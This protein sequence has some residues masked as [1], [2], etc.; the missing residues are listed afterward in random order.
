LIP[1]FFAGHQTNA[2]GTLVID[3]SRTKFLF[4]SNDSQVSLALNNSLAATAAKIQLDLLTPDDTLLATAELTTTVSKGEHSVFMHLPFKVASLPTTRTDL[5]WLRLRCRIQ[6]ADPS[7]SAVTVM[8]LAQIAPELFEVQAFASPMLHDRMPY[9]T[10]VRAFNPHTNA[11]AQSVRIDGKLDFTTKTDVQGKRQTSAIT[12]REGFALLTFDLPANQSL[13]DLELT[14]TGT[15]GELRVQATRDVLYYDEPRLL[16]STDKPLYQPGQTLHIR[17]LAFG[18]SMHALANKE[19][20]LK[21]NDPEGSL[22]FRSTM[23]TSRFGVAFADWPIPEHSRLGDYLIE[24][25]LDD[26]T[27]SSRRIK[28]SRYELPNFSIK[29]TPD[30]PYYVAGQSAQVEVRA[31]YLFGQP[32]KQGHVRVVRE[33]EREWNYAEQKYDIDEG[34]SY[35]GDTDA[36]GSFRTPIDLSGEHEDFSDNSYSKFRDLRFAA[37]FTDPTTNRTEQRRFSLRITKEPIHVY[38]IRSASGRES[39]RSPLSFYLTTY[40]ADG[41]P[42]SCNVQLRRKFNNDERDQ[43]APLLRTVQTNKLGVAKVGRLL[44]PRDV[45]EGEDF[46]LAMRARDQQGRTGTATEDFDLYDEP[47]ITV[48]TNKNL[49]TPGEPIEVTI[50]SSEKEVSA[51]LEILH[52]WISL[53]SRVIKLHG[54][55]T[56]FTLP[57][58]DNYKDALIIAAYFMREDDPI[59][60]TQTVLFPRDQNLRLD[61]RSDQQAYR[62]GDSAH[63][64]FRVRN[65]DNQPSESSLGVVV[66]DQAVAERMRDLEQFDSSSPSFYSEFT[67]LLGVGESVAGL[68]RA[69]LDH[70]DLSRPVAP[71]LALAAELFLNSSYRYFVESCGSDHYV[72]SSENVF[73]E[74]I[75]KQLKQAEDVIWQHY[76]RTDQYPTDT[77]STRKI[78]AAANINLDQLLDPWGTPYRLNFFVA[79]KS[80][81]LELTTAGVDRRFGTN[82]DFAVD[83]LDW[84]YFKPIR[85]AID[86]ALMSYHE[87]TGGFIRDQETL[88]HEL[89]SQGL[90]LMTL[91]DRWSQPYNFSFNV[92]QRGLVLTISSNGPDRK[93]GGTGHLKDDFEIWDSTVDYFGDLRT[94]VNAALQEWSLSHKSFPENQA[95]L[96]AALRAG[97][98]EPDS[99]RDDW[100]NPYQLEL[101]V[102]QIYGDKP[103]VED[104]GH[105]GETPHQH[106]DLVPVTNLIGLVNLKS[107]GPD[108]KPDTTDDLEIGT[109]AGVIKSQSSPQS[110]TPKAQSVEPLLS[111]TGGIQGIVKDVNYAVVPNV[112]VTA[113]GP[114]TAAI[115][116]TT[117][118]TGSYWLRDLPAGIYEVYAEASGFKTL[119][120]TEVVVVAGQ[121]VDLDLTMNP[122]ALAETVNVTAAADSMQ[123]NASSA[124]ISELRLNGRNFQATYLRSK[125]AGKTRQATST[126]RLRDYFPETLV[127]QPSLETD[128]RGWA[129]L[130]FKLADNITT[131][132]MSVI[133]STEDGQIGVVDK[134]IKAFQPFFIELDPPKVLTEGDEI[135][136]PVVVRNYLAKPQNVSLEIKPENWFALLSAGNRTTHVAASDAARETFALRVTSAVENGKQRVTARAGDADDAIEKPVTVHPDGEERSVSTGNVSD[137]NA[138]LQFEIPTNAIPGSARGRLKIYP[139]LASHVAESVEAIMQRPYGCGEQTISSTYP[140]LLLVRYFKQI[141]QTSRLSAQAERYLQE[142][143]NRL[144]NY[145]ADSGGFTYWGRGDADIALTAYALRFLNDAS[146]LIA[147][148]DDVIEG[149][150]RWLVHVQR[151]DGSWVNSI[152]ANRMEDIRG[153]PLLSAYVLRILAKV[154]PLAKTSLPPEIKSDANFEKALAFLE[155][156]VSQ[157]SEP[158]LIASYALASSELKDQKRAE[159]ARAKLRAL[160]QSEGAGTYWALAGSTPFHSWGKAGQIEATALAI[161]A[162]AAGC[163]NSGEA[164]HREL[165]D[166]G[167]V[168]LLKE[169][170]RYGVWHSSQATINALDALLV[171]LQTGKSKAAASSTT[172]EILMN[173]VSVQSIQLPS[174][175]E[176]VTPISIDI[177]EYLR[178]GANQVEIRRPSGTEKSWVQSV[179]TYYVPWTQSEATSLG[180]A[181]SKDLRLV[182]RF[183]QSEGKV[184][185]EFICH[186]EAQRLAVEGSGMLLAEVGLP[187]GADVDRESLNLAMTK[188]G[189][190]INQYDILPDRVVFYLWPDRRGVSFDFKFRPRF[191]MK[192]MS[193]A[194][195]I[196]DYYNPDARVVVAPARF[197]IK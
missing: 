67:G 155:G 1:A 180:F 70:I 191:G 128:K 78:L 38:L 37:Y 27:V 100:G 171:F 47:T 59:L 71:D 15:R 68:T 76:Y 165:L 195:S 126:P 30:R 41:R 36:A 104:R 176:V 152:Y 98:L 22:L 150:R 34:E 177:S 44:L 131:W 9:Q 193:A 136:L 146:S 8:S 12:D 163:A 25:E 10:R 109:F 75:K 192:A 23:K 156:S 94:K 4:G 138:T 32:V 62:P 50:T 120:I 95:F 117:N 158:Y 69:D 141:G 48:S 42:A 115:E 92:A 54:G 110:P 123:T 46:D 112:R 49:F 149:A 134:E 139:N 108:K 26:E 82:D 135:S 170:D 80:D 101:K 21:I 16:V 85:R 20:G 189:W 5:L 145:R 147:V 79:N 157:I 81:V 89:R 181:T 143:Y 164:C 142:G 17:T 119:K 28:V 118:D 63:L 43:P 169:K 129:Q 18:S 194:S 56:S 133:G 77:E 159:A 137:Q 105:F 183:N 175:N 106:V 61:V 121:V 31:D 154:K 86:H 52:D 125:D 124:E 29:V 153:D 24:F 73:R 6:A 186:V 140:S 132:K 107:V 35:E 187:P 185:D 166:G 99:L 148:D 151:R 190:A 53:E 2:H 122:G 19:L 11:P 182:T 72:K 45:S 102:K 161:Q 74:P 55:R 91:R 168:Y 3:E 178:S 64:N 179:A 57:Y 127:W 116:T 162:L 83:R 87:R 111:G 160:A 113:K 66:I 114:S 184:N 13:D 33:S 97:G 144:L 7:A 84:P 93:R 60:A 96:N 40:Y 65:R 130:D 167:L 58:K 51:V 103:R 90:D 174:G 188:S 172:A 196:Y 88:A 39:R 173:G 197:V 14:L